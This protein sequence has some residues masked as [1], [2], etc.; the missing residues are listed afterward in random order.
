[1]YVCVCV[2][3]LSGSLP[4]IHKPDFVYYSSC[5]PLHPEINDISVTK[6]ESR[7]FTARGLK[8]IRKM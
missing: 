7:C 1:M 4:F 5:V 6:A 2:C 8:F 3:T